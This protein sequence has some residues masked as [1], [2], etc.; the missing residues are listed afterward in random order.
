V[1]I[2]VRDDV[3]DALEREL[4]A[5]VARALPHAHLEGR[6]YWDTRPDLVLLAREGEAIVGMRMVVWRDVVVG[7]RS[8]SIAGTGV[9]VDP[10]WQRKGIATALTTRLLEVADQCVAIVVFLGTD[11]ARPL[12]DRFGF[13]PLP[14]P[15]SREDAA[16]VVVVE[17]A[18][19]LVKELRPLSG[20]GFVDA[21]VAAGSLSL[22]RG[23][24]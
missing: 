11:Q 15:V 18:P 10:A 22:G 21:V 2:E 16:G 23:T 19:C 12:L 24:W 9:A 6:W 17:A 14:V 5:L 20:S 1:N 8:C 13:V 3:D 4:V 7:G